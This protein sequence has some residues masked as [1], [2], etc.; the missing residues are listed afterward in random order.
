MWI[1]Q[2]TY[3]LRLRLADV[4]RQDLPQI[5]SRGQLKPLTLA[6]NEGIAESTHLVVFQ[7]G[8]V[9]CEFNFYGPRI[10]RLSGYLSERATGG[11]QHVVFEPI[12]QR[13]PIQLLRQLESIKTFDLKIPVT[14]IPEVSGIDPPLG[15]ALRAMAA[16][17]GAG[18]VSTSL[19]PEPYA[20]GG[21]IDPRMLALAIS[22][23]QNPAFKEGAGRFVV[24][25]FDSQQRI[26]EIDILRGKLVSEE[27]MVFQNPTLRA[28]NSNSA[29]AAIS[30]AY[31]KVKSIIPEDE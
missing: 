24:T 20:R 17:S 11:A 7:G 2:G 14:L 9:G 28:I 27:R 13:D 18:T 23:A 19:G 31:E 10:G 21:V 12:F 16:G 3:P 8:L 26:N 25:G 4:R 30:E 5:D 29:Y 22:L 15:R 1:Q 6:A